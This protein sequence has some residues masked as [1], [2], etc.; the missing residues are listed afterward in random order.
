MRSEHQYI[1][2]PDETH[3][4]NKESLFLAGSIT[5]CW[6]WQKEMSQKLSK[7][8]ILTICNPRRKNFKSFKGAADY[9]ESRKQIEWEFKLLQQVTQISFW[10]SFETLAPITLYE[11]GRVIEKNVQYFNDPMKGQRIFIGVDPNFERKFD[12]ETQVGLQG[13][14]DDISDNINHLIERI[15]IYNKNLELFKGEF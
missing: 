10:F 9:E 11:L 8:D 1:E 6:D 12:V 2:A 5:G 3:I 7:I 13:Y 14:T 4:K 15:R